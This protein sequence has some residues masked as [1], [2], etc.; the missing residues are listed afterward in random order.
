MRDRRR[1][2]EEEEEAI[3]I[4]IFFVVFASFRFGR[5]EKK[6]GQRPTRGINK[7]NTGFFG[8]TIT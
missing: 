6:K 2:K 5:F 1:R 7:F 3:L 8:L 4:I